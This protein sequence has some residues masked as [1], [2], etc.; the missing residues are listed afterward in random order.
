MIK[1]AIV[2]NIASGK[3]VA[4]KFLQEN[5]CVVY[6]TDDM[7]HEILKTHS[8]EIIKTFKD[9]DILSNGEIDR[10]KLAKTVFSSKCELKRLEEIIHP[11]IKEELAKIFKLNY[12]MVFIS[13]P[14]LFEA[15]MDGMFDK[16]IYIASDEKTRLKRLM[17]RSGLSL[18]EA[19]IRINAQIPDDKKIKKSD[20]VIYNN[21]S[22]EDLKIQINEVLNDIKSLL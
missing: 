7:A 15:G 1:A 20:Y 11:L 9:Y 18:E 6:D 14:Q 5:G 22:K 12:E 2:G 13:V 8:S 17:K 19:K 10:T 3:S 4:E 16:I 21:S